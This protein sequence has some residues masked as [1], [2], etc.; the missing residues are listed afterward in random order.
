MDPYGAFIDLHQQF[1]RISYERSYEK[2]HLVMWRESYSI[3]Q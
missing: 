3:V 2:T 1:S